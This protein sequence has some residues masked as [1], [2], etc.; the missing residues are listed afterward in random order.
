MAEG[1]GD[2]AH[3]L[4]ALVARAHRRRAGTEPGTGTSPAD[5]ADRLSDMVM[6][7]AGRHTQWQQW[8]S[9]AMTHVEALEAREHFAT[10]HRWLARQLG[11][12]LMARAPCHVT[13]YLHYGYPAVSITR[14]ARSNMAVKIPIPAPRLA[15]GD[16]STVS[17]APRIGRWPGRTPDS[18][19]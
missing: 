18:R 19:R 15:P 10:L 11:G 1:T 14:I 9:G 12:E 16:R 3:R 17:L 4:R 2:P 7:L 6:D 5:E 8:L 13:S